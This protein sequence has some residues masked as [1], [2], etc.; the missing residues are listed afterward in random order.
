MSSLTKAQ[1]RDQLKV[2]SDVVSALEDS[3]IETFIDIALRAYSEKLPELRISEDNVVVSGQERYDFPS[4][5]LS[6]AKIVNPETGVEITFTIEDNGNGNQI[7]LGNIKENSFDNLL[8]ADYY[9]SPINTSTSVGSG[10]V[11]GYDTF[12]IEY[13]LLH[14]MTSIN[15]DAL[16]MLYHY[17]LYCSYEKRATDA[18]IASET[19]ETVTPESISDSN[20]RGETTTIKYPSRTGI[21][22][23]WSDLA[24]SALKSFNNGLGKFVYGVRG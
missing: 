22:K 10:S 11:T 7:N 16:E 4:N 18:L 6:I 23:I 12:D 2:R 17:V 5:A 13:T 9:D 14:Q 3:T 19:D 24:R 20:A 8:E 15:D 21:A 1:F